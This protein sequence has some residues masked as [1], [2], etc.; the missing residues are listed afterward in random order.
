MHK[1]SCATFVTRN[2]F[3]FR[4]LHEYLS[5]FESLKSLITQREVY[6]GRIEL[7]HLSAIAR[8]APL[9]PASFLASPA[10]TRSNPTLHLVWILSYG[11]D[12]PH[13]V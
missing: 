11:G 13:V 12:R 3:T 5:R 10:R 2:E 9:A 7:V 4:S 8:N 6:R 1:S